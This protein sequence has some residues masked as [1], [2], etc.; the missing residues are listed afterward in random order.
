M[1]SSQINQTPM[2]EPKVC[3]SRFREVE[4]KCV[5]W[6]PFFP[7]KVSS[8]HMRRLGQ[9]FGRS[10]MK[11]KS[12]RRPVLE[13]STRGAQR[14]SNFL[15]RGGQEWNR[16]MVKIPI[17]LS[18]H[19]HKSYIPVKKSYGIKSSLKMAFEHNDRNQTS[20]NRIRTRTTSR[21]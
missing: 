9:S 3:T 19:F 16:K 18:S 4:L 8:S 20:T 5:R 11:K 14:A 21:T 7:I 6:F 15:H 1:N 12:V 10:R 17:L 2:R 13:E